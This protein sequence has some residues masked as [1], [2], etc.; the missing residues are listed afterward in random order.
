MRH[1]K[2]E[3]ITTMVALLL[4][5]AAI[6]AC[7]NGYDC[8]LNN[9]AY[10]NMGFYTITDGKENPYAYPSP[11]TVSLMIN[12]KDSIMI[13]HIT[14]ASEVSLPMSYTYDCDTVVFHYDDGLQDSLYISHT[15]TPYYQSM[16]CGTLMF[17]QLDG[18]RHTNTWIENAT[19][20]NKNV[21]FEGNENI[22]IYFYK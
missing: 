20:V 4:C 1:R 21:N 6:T 14:D 13:N 18:I 22:K 11:L 5:I 12:G 9:T 19:I 17:H 2:R 3:I 7:D 10:D 16:E 8:E 15:N